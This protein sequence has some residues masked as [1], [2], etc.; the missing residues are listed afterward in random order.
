MAAVS[1]QLVQTFD[2]VYRIFSQNSMFSA[3]IQEENLCA[4]PNFMPTH[5]ISGKALDLYEQAYYTEVAS[6]TCSYKF[7]H[8]L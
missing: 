7:K 5:K 3:K 6:R 1:L 4:A 8:P 2:L